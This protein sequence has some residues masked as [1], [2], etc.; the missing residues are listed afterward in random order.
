MI[1]MVFSSLLLQSP[2]IR[3]V[4]DIDAI[5]AIDAIDDME[6]NHDDIHRAQK[7]LEDFDMSSL[8]PCWTMR[9]QCLVVSA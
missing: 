7:C 8:L 9:F 6:Y 1:L 2:N 3:N 5:D 4:D